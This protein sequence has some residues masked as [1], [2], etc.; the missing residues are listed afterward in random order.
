MVD[1]TEESGKTN[2]RMSRKDALKGQQSAKPKVVPKTNAHL[3]RAQDSMEASFQELDRLSQ[4]QQAQYSR[5]QETEIQTPHLD[6]TL[7]HVPNV[8]SLGY[9]AP[10]ESLDELVA[11][12]DAA[13]N[14]I[15]VEVPLHLIKPSPLNHRD[16]KLDFDKF[17]ELIPPMPTGWVSMDHDEYVEALWS[18]NLSKLRSSGELT[19]KDILAEKV[20]IAK[21]FGVSQSIEVSGLQSEPTCCVKFDPLSGKPK[22][23][24]IIFGER[25]LR[26]ANLM[27]LSS[28]AVKF[29]TTATDRTNSTSVNLDRS[30]A[31]LTENHTNE[32]LTV[33]ETLHSYGEYLDAYRLDYEAENGAGTAS[34]LPKIHLIEKLRPHANNLSDANGLR[35]LRVLLH[36]QEKLLLNLC[37]TTITKLMPIYNVA[38][39][40][41]S[42]AKELNQPCES[43]H[44]YA[45]AINDVESNCTIQDVPVEILEKVKRL[46]RVLRNEVKPAD[47]L[48]GR[49]TVAKEYSATT[50][51]DLPKQTAPRVRYSAKETST[52]L[53]KFA[54]VANKGKAAYDANVRAYTQALLTVTA[55][56]G[57]TISSES[58]SRFSALNLL[59]GEER[60][61]ENY[62]LKLLEIIEAVQPKLDAV[63]PSVTGATDLLERLKSGGNSLDII[64]KF[65]N[66]NSRIST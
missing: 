52:K 4:E 25:R 45:A 33:A 23:A 11:L 50:P 21:L 63:T 16:F 55:L 43:E 30:G 3:L 38:G 39:S 12:I 34:K 14:T 48:S 10:V 57:G 42:L 29:Q 54:I 13:K 47:Y 2:K 26:A 7:D 59:R 20:R 22:F 66:E 17:L 46:A 32:T 64:A 6:S 53:S 9:K 62:K 24:E 5:G 58:I 15:V 37:M 61:H 40:S 60:E 51:T 18:D 65:V 19:I 56:E 36:P 27:K 28:I 41:L 1:Q 8:V 31:R 35:Y 44:V 49:D